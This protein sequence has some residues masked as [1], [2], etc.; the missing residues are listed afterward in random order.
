MR[1]EGRRRVQQAADKPL[2]SPCTDLRA[3]LFVAKARRSSATA[4]LPRLDLVPNLRARLGPTF[5]SNLLREFSP[6]DLRRTYIS[7]LLDRGVDLATA[8][9]LAGHASPN[10]TKRYDRRGERARQAA[11]EG[12]IVPYVEPSS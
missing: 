12:I 3:D 4:A 7:V 6:H 11:A 8:A 10:T 5:V 9:D 1:S 2:P